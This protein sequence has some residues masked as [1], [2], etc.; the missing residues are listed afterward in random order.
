MQS[1]DDAYFVM[2]VDPPF[3]SVQIDQGTIENEKFVGT[4]ATFLWGPTA[5]T[6]IGQPVDGFIVGKTKGGTALAMTWVRPYASKDALLAPELTPCPNFQ[7][8]ESPDEP[9][10]KAVV[11]SPPAGKVV[12]IASIKFYPT[13]RG[14]LASLFHKDIEAARAF[15]KIHYPQLADK[16]ENGSYQLIP[17]ARCG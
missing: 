16:L 10:G 17:L 11:F 15:M 9:H 8:D 13:P 6:F 14:S 7:S 2:G 4:I 3:T 12:Y 1:N 5:A